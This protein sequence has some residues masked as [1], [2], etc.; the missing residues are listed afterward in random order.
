MS[1]LR[2]PASL[3]RAIKRVTLAAGLVFGLQ[4]VAQAASNPYY[5]YGI[6]G[7]G[8]IRELKLQNKATGGPEILYQKTVLDTK[9]T[10]PAESFNGLSYDIVRDDLFFA[11]GGPTVSQTDLYWWSKQS[12]S[13]VDISTFGD[14]KGIPTS[15]AYYNDAI[16]FFQNGEIPGSS[17]VKLYK[18]ALTYDANG[19]PTASTPIYFNLSLADPIGA[20]TS[21][22]T[23]GTGPCKTTQ[24]FGDIAINAAGKLYAATANVSDPATTSDFYTVNLGS[25]GNVVAGVG[26]CD[27]ADNLAVSGLFGY[28]L[29]F[30][31]GGSGIDPL[32]LIGTQ[33]PNGQLGLVNLLDGSFIANTISPQN[34][35][36]GS[37]LR[38]LAGPAADPFVPVPGPL[39]LLGVG[40]AFGW[41]RR[42]RQRIARSAKL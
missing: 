37:I 24:V 11:Y 6:D 19:V 41:S 18:V 2:P 20:C 28:Q 3:A 13:I 1:L 9:L 26:S 23:V 15:A 17:T 5:V 21:G 30:G 31:Y 32:T 42:L 10:G 7:S 22:L 34:T 27:P 8:L 39:P 29:S 25:C 33:G 38:D 40:A 12:Q 35:V 16:W 4:G 36:N 14:L